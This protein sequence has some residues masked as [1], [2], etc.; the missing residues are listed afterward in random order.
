MK[1]TVNI[2]NK[3]AAAAIAL[4]FAFVFAVVSFLT[5]GQDV[6]RVGA[7]SVLTERPQQAASNEAKP[8][9]AVTPRV[10]PAAPAVAKAEPKAAA[11]RPIKGG[12]ASYYG[13][14]FAGRPTANGE[15]FNPAEMTAAHRTLPFGTRVR[16]TNKD[17]GNTVVVR[18]ND[19]GPYAHDR[20]IDLS[21]GAAKKIGMVATGT[22]DVKL[23]V[24][25][26]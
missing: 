4:F 17:N 7:A 8:A 9:V 25:A 20:V 26:S 16:V 2:K 3:K 18:I 22:A 21:Q 13:R 14:G 15:T 24:L 12:E 10:K 19:R 11:V 5:P 1:T 23:E 6:A